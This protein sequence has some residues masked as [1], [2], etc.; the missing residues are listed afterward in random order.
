M[1]IAVV[2]GLLGLGCASTVDRGG[3]AD[4]GGVGAVVDAWH[5]A[6]AAGDFHA[7]FGRMT[8]DAVFLGTDAS[9]R[10]GRAAFEDFARPHFDGVEAWTYRPRDRHVAFSGDGRTAWFDE[11]LDH[12]RYGELR[13]TGVLRRGDDGGWRIAHYSLTFTVPND[14]A[15]EVVGVIRRG[16]PG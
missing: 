10:W 6:A 9:E 3:V 16:S 1:A 13:G 11:M 4:A 2:A 5:A 12:D 7:Y 14:R 8:D 15:A